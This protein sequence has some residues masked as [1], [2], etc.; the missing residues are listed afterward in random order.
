MGGEEALEEVEEEEEEKKLKGKEEE[1][2]SPPLL[3]NFTFNPNPTRPSVPRIYLLISRRRRRP[4]S[5]LSQLFVCSGAFLS[6]SPRTLPFP[7]H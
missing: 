7:P 2:S 6:L 5:K 3:L 4:L 1:S